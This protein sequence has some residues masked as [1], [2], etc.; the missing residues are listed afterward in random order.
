M[1]HDV[2]DAIRSDILAGASLRD[3]RARAGYHQLQTRR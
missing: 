1:I 2:E 3:A